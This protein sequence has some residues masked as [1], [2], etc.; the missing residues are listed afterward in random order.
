MSRLRSGLT[1]SICLI[2]TMITWS[3][4]GQPEK[5]S[6]R[7]I[8]N[9]DNGWRFL[10]ADA[11]SAEIPAFDDSQWRKLDVP[12]DW[13]IEG[14]YDMTNPTGRGGGYLPA[15]IGWYRKS[16]ILNE[17]EA[18]KKFFIEFD[19]VMANSD[20]WINGF[21]LGKRPYGYI[22]FSYDLTDH[23]KFGKNESNV[24]AVRA[25]NSIQP[26]SRYYTGAGIYRHVRLVTTN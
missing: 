1:V 15:G 5:Q 6:S 12:H 7:I 11:T 10:K 23:L 3:L 14:P 25:D 21:H 22:G 26:A 16:F 20:V 17:S 24:I 13:S 2:L 9:F 8:Q 19:G 18:Q 4:E